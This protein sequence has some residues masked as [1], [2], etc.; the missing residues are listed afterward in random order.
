M[1]PRL[2]HARRDAAA[3]DSH[4]SYRINFLIT[5]QNQASAALTHAT[6]SAG[7]EQ[8][9]KPL[10]SPRVIRDNAILTRAGTCSKT[11]KTSLS[12]SSLSR[13]GQ[14]ATQ[15]EIQALSGRCEVRGIVFDGEEI[16]DLEVS[17]SRDSAPCD[18]MSASVES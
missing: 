1:P 14:A 9:V 3:C 15:I 6:S 8:A 17:R 11:S 2:N 16:A 5:R 13:S 4:R 7:Y 12:G 18:E 10:T